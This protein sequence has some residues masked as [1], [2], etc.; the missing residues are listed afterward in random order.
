LQELQL[1]PT[2]RSY[3][4][5]KDTAVP[6]A[7]DFYFFNWTNPEELFEENF[8]PDLVEVGPYRFM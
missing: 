4:L 7:L 3:A 1:S 6:I 8:K 5:W 2:S